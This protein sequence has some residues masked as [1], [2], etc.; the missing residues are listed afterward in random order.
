MRQLLQW[1]KRIRKLNIIITFSLIPSVCGDKVIYNH[2][3][4]ISSY[5][6]FV[7]SEQRELYGKVIKKEHISENAFIMAWNDYFGLLDKGLD[8]GVAHKPSFIA[9]LFD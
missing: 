2:S 1:L 7:T 4:R 3:K 6:Y 8:Y 5:L 9:W